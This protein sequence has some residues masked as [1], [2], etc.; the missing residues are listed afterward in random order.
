MV[1]VVETIVT[2]VV[3]VEVVVV[4]VINSYLLVRDPLTLHLTPDQDPNFSPYVF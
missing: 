4:V 1:L 2:V 3:E